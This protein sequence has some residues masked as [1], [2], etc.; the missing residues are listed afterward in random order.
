[1]QCDIDE[2]FLVDRRRVRLLAGLQRAG[3]IPGMHEIRICCGH[4]IS[5]GDSM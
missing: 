4:H 1:M 2:A 5:G 3:L